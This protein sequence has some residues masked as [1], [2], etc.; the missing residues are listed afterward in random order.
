MFRITELIYHKVFVKEKEQEQI[1]DM[2]VLVK[3]CCFSCTKA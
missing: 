1:N 2:S 3:S